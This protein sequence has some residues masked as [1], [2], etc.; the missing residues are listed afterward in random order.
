MNCLGFTN[1]SFHDLYLGMPTHVGRSPKEA[2]KFLPYRE[3]QC[4]IPWSDRPLSRAGM[5]T[6]L[7]SIIQAIP[8]CVMS[9]I[10]ISVSTCHKLWQMFLDFWCGRE[11][12]KKKLHWRSWEWLSAPKSLG[13]LG[14]RDLVL[15]NQA[16]L[17]RQCWRLLTEPG[18]LCARVLKGRYFPNGDFWDA[19]KPIS[20]CYTWRSILFGRE[21]V[22]KGIH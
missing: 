22:K 20:S 18:S 8:T 14:F 9:C 15:F 6:M 1:E 10:Q 13:G 4:I 17:G 3:W 2:F 16:M 11:D 21:L 19:P 12:G 5:E 7:K